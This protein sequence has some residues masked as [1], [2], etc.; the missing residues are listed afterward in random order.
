[1]GVWPHSSTGNHAYP[2]DMVSTGSLS[3]LLGIS[4]NVTLTGS[5]KPLAFLESGKF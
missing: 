2:L 1:M 5:W 3:L 4:A